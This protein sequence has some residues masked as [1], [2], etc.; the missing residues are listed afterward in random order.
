MDMCDNAYTPEPPEESLCEDPLGT[1]ADTQTQIEEPVI[2]ESP[3]TPEKRWGWKL[4]GICV[5]LLAAC[6]ITAM[7]VSK[8]WADKFANMELAVKDRFNAMEQTYGQKYN[9][10]GIPD[11]QLPDQG[12][13]TPSQIYAENVQ[14][15]VAINAYGSNIGS[16]FII[17]ADGYVVT[18][19]HVVE[20][21]SAVKVVTNDGATLDAQVMGKDAINDVALLKIPGEN[22]PFV[23]VGSSSAMAVGDMVVAIGNPL[24]ELTSTLTVGYVSAKD[25]VLN[26]DG[27]L[28]NMLQTDAA[29]NSGNSGGPL[30]NTKG[31]VIGITTAKI[32]GNSGS[33][34]SDS[35]AT[36]EGLGFAI[37]MDDVKDILSD[38]KEFGYVTGAYL[39]VTVRSVDTAAQ[40]YGLPAGA[41]VTEVVKDGA[42]D[43]AGIRKGDI[44]V[45]LG[46]YDVNSLATLTRV[47]RHFEAGQTVSVIVYRNGL[48]ETLSITLEEKPADN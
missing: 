26:T 2:P 38:L 29:I 43:K 24:G 41:Y 31:E 5:L 14:A 23:T 46:G 40:S 25:R 18:N 33:Q 20:G 32:S 12:P 27:S 3:E 34:N 10:S 16:G 22:H 39:G 11:T 15:V 6:G 4:S 30:F 28:V 42:A 48:R 19:S 21:V 8:L 47:L 44:I 13:L 45:T 17:T 1:G 7:L 36:I 35:G 37:P 9:Q